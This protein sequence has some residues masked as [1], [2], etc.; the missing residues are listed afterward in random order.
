ME[1]GEKWA[2][3][4]FD[5]FPSY[6]NNRD[7]VTISHVIFGGGKGKLPHRDFHLESLIHVGKSIPDFFFPKWW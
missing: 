3:E 4:P 6:K 5:L 2:S 7:H 1:V